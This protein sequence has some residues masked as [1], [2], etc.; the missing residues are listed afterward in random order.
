MPHGPFHLLP[1]HALQRPNGEYVAS[2]SAVVYWPSISTAV[3]LLNH[4]PP[5]PRI[6]N[7][8]VGGLAAEGDSHPEY[9]E[10][11]AEIFVGVRCTLTKAFGMV[12]AS[13]AR[14]LAMLPQHDLVHLTC[15]G[16]FDPADP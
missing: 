4:A 14:L 12:G 16:F 2:R 7:L 5:K 10:R 8:L 6:N 15:H 13:R 11:D 9:F 3:Q 1:F